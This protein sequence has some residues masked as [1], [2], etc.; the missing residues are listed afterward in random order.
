MPSNGEVEGSSESRDTLVTRVGA[1]RWA[2]LAAVVLLL[3][4][5][6]RIAASYLDCK[7]TPERLSAWVFSQVALVSELRAVQEAY[8]SSHGS[9]T[10][11]P[12]DLSIE[13]DAEVDIAIGEATE[14]GYAATVH[15]RRTGVVCSLAVDR[16]A[17]RPDDVVMGCRRE[18]S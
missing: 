7:R 17:Q 16:L 13:H 8:R 1:L 12:A 5:T 2:A 6:A 3:L 4:A 18:G 14:S 11:N 15:D 9:Y 10:A